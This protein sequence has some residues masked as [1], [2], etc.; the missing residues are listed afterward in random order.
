MIIKISDIPLRINSLPE[1]VTFAG[2][3]SYII[4]N[5]IFGDFCTM[6]NFFFHVQG[7]EPILRM[8]CSLKAYCARPVSILTV[9]TFAARCLSASYPMRELQAAKDGTICGRET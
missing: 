6:S 2:N 3:I 7:P 1:D 5:R 8:H 4:S 9:P